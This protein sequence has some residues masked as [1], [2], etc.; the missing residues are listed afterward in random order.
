MVLSGVAP[1]REGQRWQLATPATARSELLSAPADSFPNPEA[2]NFTQIGRRSTTLRQNDP[3]DN[4][5]LASKI[6][7]FHSNWE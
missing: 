2:L 6:L 1:G 5:G 3:N 7:Q 4:E